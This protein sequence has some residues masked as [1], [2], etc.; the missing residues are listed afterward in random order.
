MVVNPQHFAVALSYDASRMAAPEV[1]A[2]GRN[3]H[4]LML[5]RRAFQLGIPI[6]ENPPLARALYHGCEP[7][8]PVGPDHYRAIA[9]LYLKLHRARAANQ[10][11]DDAQQDDQQE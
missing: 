7:G 10:K 1:T 6:Y 2:K 9:D 3:N 11:N 4:A 5:K 8:G